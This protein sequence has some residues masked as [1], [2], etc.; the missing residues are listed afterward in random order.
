MVVMK[1]IL[2]EGYRSR[3]GLVSAMEEEFHENLEIH[4]NKR[5]QFTDFF[6]FSTLTFSL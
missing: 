6:N 4:L 3:I 5:R 2:H 1:G